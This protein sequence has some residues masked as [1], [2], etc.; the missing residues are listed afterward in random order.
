MAEP[1]RIY[2]DHAA[3]TPLCAEARE[4]MAGA[5]DS[6]FGNPSSLH[7]EGRAA[8]G[9]LEDARARLANL[10]GAQG[11]RVIFTSGGTEADN[12]AVLGI[13]LPPDRRDA[14]PG[15]AITS[16]VEHPAVLNAFGIAREEG[17][18]LSV[19]DVNRDGRVDPDA[20]RAAMRADTRLVSIMAAN[21][22][23]GTVQPIPEIGRVARDRGIPFHTDAVQLLGK[24][25]L[26]LTSLPVDLVSLSAHKIGGPRGIG[27]LCVREG[28]ALQ[29][30]LRGG[31]QEGGLRAGTESVVL[32][33]GFARAAEIALGGREGERARIAALRDRLRRALEVTIG[34][35]TFN[36]PSDGALPN[37]LNVAFHGL[38]GEALLLYLDRLGVSVSTG[39]ACSQSGRRPSHV[40]EAMGRSASEVRSSL[41]FS[42]GR[43][44]GEWEIDD[45]VR[46]LGRAI[47]ELQHV[48]GE[49]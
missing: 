5:M 29:P 20:V 7:A 18:A 42:L 46:R 6:L 47:G 14:G 17:L 27:I 48:A 30:L 38:N 9:A 4:A 21:N 12:A 23:V 43:A 37:I 33:I 32:A 49:S 40:L 13:L 44:T 8:R 2:L 41:R 10:L 26:D 3:T 25:P 36:T 35:V 16:A 19:L 39:S 15:H 22:E 11:F 45:A 28:I 31:Q 1:R 34:R 24:A